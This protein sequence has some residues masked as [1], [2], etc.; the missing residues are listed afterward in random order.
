MKEIKGEIKSFGV[1][2]PYPAVVREIRT[3]IHIGLPFDPQ[4]EEVGEPIGGDFL[5]VWDTG[6]TSSNICQEV[7]EKLNLPKIRETAANGASGRYLANVYMGSIFLPNLTIISPIELIGCDKGVGCDILI[8]MDII[9]LGDFLISTY[10]GKTTFS[11]QAP[12]CGLITLKQI[13]PDAT[14]SSISGS[15]TRPKVGRNDP[16]LCGSG[17]KFKQCCGND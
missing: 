17:K 6:A 9:T 10:D 8:G 7:A 12:S 4:K 2:F 5:A 16:C 1:A 14:V 3:P 15:K 13:R 11:F